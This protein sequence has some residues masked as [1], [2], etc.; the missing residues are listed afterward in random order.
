MN[1]SSQNGSVQT[2]PGPNGS[3]QKGSVPVSSAPF[4]AVPFKSAPS[5]TP[6]PESEP[7]LLRIADVARIMEVSESTVKRYTYRGLL[8]YIERRAESGK[9]AYLFRRADVLSLMAELAAD[10]SQAPAVSPAILAAR[11]VPISSD[12]I[13]S[14][15]TEPDPFSSSSSSSDRVSSDQ[16][17]DQIGSDRV[18]SVPIG[19]DQ[20][21]SVQVRSDLLHRLEGA[22]TAARVHSRRLREESRVREETQNQVRFLQAQLDASR[23]AEHEMRLLLAQQQQQLTALTQ[24][25]EE[26]VRPALPAPKQPWWRFWGRG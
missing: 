5:P 3:D 10:R 19:L 17:A 16:P 15:P 12:P 6:A 18:G 13:R 7:E 1:E 26:R 22:Q 4:S 9:L 8:P 25:T 20:I 24:L 14:V 2:G 23:Q 21:T 11:T